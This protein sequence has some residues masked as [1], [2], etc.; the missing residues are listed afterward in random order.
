MKYDLR[1]GRER[2]ERMREGEREK[3]CGR[4]ISCSLIVIIPFPLEL[5]TERL[6][7]I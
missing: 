4:K 1:S 6:R 2:G 5:S 7:D 3:V